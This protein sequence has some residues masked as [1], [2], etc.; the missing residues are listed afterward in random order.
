MSEGWDR[1]AFRAAYVAD[2]GTPASARSYVS[3]LNRAE[4]VLEGLPEG[5]GSGLIDRAERLP[6]HVWGGERERRDSL[7]ALRCFVRLAGGVAAT[8]PAVI[9]EDRDDRLMQLLRDA[10][11]IGAEYYRL[12]GKPLGVTGEIAE[13]EAA[14]ALGLTL[15]VARTPGHDA[16]DPANGDA[17]QIKGRAV[18]RDDRYRGMCPAI[19]CDADVQVVVLVLL[20]RTTLTAIEVWRT[21]I[22]AVRR[23][24]AGL[25]SARR[26]AEGVLAITQFTSIATRVVPPVPSSSPVP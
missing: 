25:A 20:D 16:I 26:R 22:A 10:Q 17:V 13:Y 6:V 8:P 4:R 3:Y 2:G 18:A 11:R 12:T 23:R 19:L 14:R 7:A 1:E 5:G 21:D 9:R 24:I 15:C